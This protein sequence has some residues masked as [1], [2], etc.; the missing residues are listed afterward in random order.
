ML[1]EICKLFVYQLVFLHIAEI[2]P[3]I[4]K[5]LLAHDPK[6]FSWLPTTYIAEGERNTWA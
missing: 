3:H 5:D 4:S 6:G 1:L 2:E